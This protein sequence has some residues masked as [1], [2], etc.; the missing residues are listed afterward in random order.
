LPL[1]I[2]LSAEQVK[3]ITGEVR[4]YILAQ[5]EC[6]ADRC[7]PLTKAQ[8]LAMAGFFPD[9]VL[10]SVR[11]GVLKGERIENPGFYKNLRAWGID[12]ALDFEDMAAITLV[13]VVVSHVPFYDQ[14][15]FHELVHVM[16]Y[17]ALGVDEFARRYVQGFLTGGS[18]DRIPLEVQA[19]ELDGRFALDPQQVFPVEKQVENWMK[20][21]MI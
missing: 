7:L 4:D 20:Q 21:G 1:P 8:A 15:L 13:D 6:F 14:L 10:A 16:Q 17:R 19:Y 18:Y 3:W 9:A 2:E 12:T 11:L 5:R